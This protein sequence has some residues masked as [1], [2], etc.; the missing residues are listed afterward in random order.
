MNKKL[1]LVALATI[2][3]AGCSTPTTPSTEKIMPKETST[4]PVTTTSG[5]TEAMVKGKT[6]EA[7][8][9]YTSPGGPET[10]GVKL[11]VDNGIITDVV[12]TPNATNPGSI[13]WE[14]AFAGGIK[15]QVVGKP[16]AD[17]QV[18]KVSGS[19]LT[20]TGFNDAL[21]KIKAQM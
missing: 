8:G 7:T 19:S 13:K 9:A 12:V 10:I 3:L 4:A 18:G 17:L 15:E 16:L 21:A 2:L 5:T 11:T 6:Y 14:T 1:P 20:G